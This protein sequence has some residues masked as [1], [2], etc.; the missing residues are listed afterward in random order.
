MPALQLQAQNLATPLNKDGA[1]KKASQ[2]MPTLAPFMHVSRRNTWIKP[3]RYAP[4]IRFPFIAASFTAFMDFIAD[5]VFATFIA[6]LPAGAV[7][8]AFAF[9]FM[10]V[11]TLGFRSFFTG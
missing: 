11:V 5:A 9:A 1:E 2:S 10:A 7:G 4:P 8:F 3:V 6:V